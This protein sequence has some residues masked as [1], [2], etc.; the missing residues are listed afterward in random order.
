[1]TQAQDIIVTEGECLMDSR[2]LAARL[3][4]EHETLVRNITRHKT[5][6]EAKSLL[7]QVVGKPPKGSRGGRPEVSYLLDER[8]CLI[9]AGSLKKGV[10]A[11]EWHD[12]LVDAFLQ[13]RLRV[14]QL[15]A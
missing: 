12:T 3:G 8:Q 2:V 1:M 7:R 9:L 15:E 13:A 4:Y 10:E 11:D 5:R 14:K 6:L